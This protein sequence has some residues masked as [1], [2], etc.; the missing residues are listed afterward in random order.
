MLQISLVNINKQQDESPIILL[1]SN[2]LINYVK[3]IV[4]IENYTL[5]RRLLIKLKINIGYI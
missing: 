1:N 2:N 5:I 4:F 3:N